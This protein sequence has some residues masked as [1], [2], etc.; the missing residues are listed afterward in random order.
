MD[1]DAEK[2]SFKAVNYLLA[3]RYA[4]FLEEQ[5]GQGCKGL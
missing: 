4:S 3:P 2:F 1:A 5:K